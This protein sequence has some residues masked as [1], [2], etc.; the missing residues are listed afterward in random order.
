MGEVRRLLPPDGLIA[1]VLETAVDVADV[2]LARRWALEEERAHQCGRGA[3][4]RAYRGSAFHTL[5]GCKVPKIDV[6]L[7]AADLLKLARA[8]A[9]RRAHFA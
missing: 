6:R 3:A 1:P 7:P 5:C 4:G 9:Q 2:G 8:V